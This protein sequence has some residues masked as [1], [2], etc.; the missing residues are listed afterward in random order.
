MIEIEIRMP[1]TCTSQ[2]EF[3]DLK[4]EGRNWLRAFGHWA[5]GIGV[6]G[7]GWRGEERR[8]EE[9]RGEEQWGKG[10]KGGD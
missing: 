9:R 6:D 2:Y 7:E 10:G 3:E 5:L 4:T 1:R 8:G